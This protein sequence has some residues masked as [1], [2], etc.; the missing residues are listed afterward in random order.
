[1]DMFV[2]LD[3]HYCFSCIHYFIW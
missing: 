3:K 1:M 2:Q